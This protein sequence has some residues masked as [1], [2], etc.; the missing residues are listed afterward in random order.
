MNPRR[1]LKLAEVYIKFNNNESTCSRWHG[2]LYCQQRNF[3]VCGEKGRF[4]VNLSPG[5]TL[6]ISVQVQMWLLS[7]VG[8]TFESL[9]THVSFC[10]TNSEDI[11]VSTLGMITKH[12][13]FDRDRTNICARNLREALL[14]KLSEYYV[15]L[16][17]L[18]PVAL[19]EVP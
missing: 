12:I 4:F 10:F 17:M 6:Q 9:K 14:C 18:W 2:W 13:R 19:E 8:N 16:V 3:S 1:P 5:S 11:I 15:K 7:E